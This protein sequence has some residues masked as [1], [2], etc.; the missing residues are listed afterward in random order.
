M[1]APDG[2]KFYKQF[3]RNCSNFEDCSV[4]VE[5]NECEAIDGKWTDFE[6]I[7]DCKEI[8]DGQW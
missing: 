8:E 5:F 4:M 1:Y 3:E 7:E 6:I 2:V